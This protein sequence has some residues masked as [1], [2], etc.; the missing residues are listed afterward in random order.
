MDVWRNLQRRTA[1]VILTVAGIAIGIV[2]LVVV[3]GL[4]ERLQTI[5]SRSALLNNGVVFAF[6]EQGERD[7][8][9]SSERIARAM[10]DIR[11]LPGVAAVIPEVILPYQ[12]GAEARARFGPPA[13][14]FGLPDA[15]RPMIARVSG[16]ALDG[17]LDAGG[18]RHALV[19]A[20]FATSE[21]VRPGDML[22]LY[23][24]SYTVAGILAKSFT[25][26][27]A[28][29][30]VPF[31]DAQQ[32]LY[33]AIPPDS[34]ALPAVALSALMLVVRPSTDTHLL[35][36]R[37]NLIEGL[38][39]RD[40]VESASALQ[41]T[42]RI[43]DTIVFGAAFVALIVGAISIVNTMTMTVSERTREIGIRKAIG[44]TDADILR[45]FVLEAALLGALGGAA[46]VFVGLALTWVIDARNAA[47]GNLE[48]FAITPRLA[49]GAFAFAVLLSVIAGA[50]PALRA[51]RLAPS[52]A[53]RQLT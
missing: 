14:I 26:F 40:P 3:G 11:A 15:A 21:R 10:R 19:G 50:I 12:F 17:S 7:R 33:Q 38:H 25:V 29:V 46:G 43:F 30:V 35:A 22:S 32:L 45:E 52:D 34:R 49:L 16:M 48:V 23:G 47:A 44:A 8:A 41:S 5:V 51:A 18:D 1:R 6:A 28:A 39:A 2:A 24:N 37:V 9:R 13:F 27:D 36:E 53:L 20:D 4:A 31:A 42:T